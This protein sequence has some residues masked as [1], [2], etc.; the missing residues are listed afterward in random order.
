MARPAFHS[1]IAAMSTPG[2]DRS[3]GASRQWLS[4][5]DG[6]MNDAL[7]ESTEVVAGPR[8][9]ASGGDR[10]DEEDTIRNAV[11]NIDTGFPMDENL[12]YSA[13]A[14]PQTNQTLVDQQPE[15]PDVQVNTNDPE[16]QT[17]D[18]PLPHPPDFKPFF[19]IITDPVTGIHHHPTVH[20]VFSDDDP[21]LLTSASL[22]SL[23]AGQN[24]AD[25]EDGSVEERYVVVDMA[26]DGKNVLSAASMSPNWQGLKATVAQAPSWGGAGNGGN[27]L[28]LKVE[29]NE[30]DDAGVGGQRR[31]QGDFEALVR[32]FGTRLEALNSVLGR[33]ETVDEDL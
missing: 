13:R 32:E 15:Y 29:G 19:T 16:D 23:D 10:P 12:F 26:A 14:P 33:D 31:R 22:A 1:T 3:T 27:G 24:G 5:N 11:N 7:P 18:A 20:Y 8:T 30:G 4:N 21:A 17:E 25:T 28:M 2:V 9:E 6:V